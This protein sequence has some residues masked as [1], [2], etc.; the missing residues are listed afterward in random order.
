[1]LDVHV[2]YQSLDKFLDKCSILWHIFASF[3]LRLSVVTG[4]T[5]TLCIPFPTLKQLP[6]I[7][8]SIDSICLLPCNLTW[9][10]FNGRQLFEY[11]C[12][13]LITTVVDLS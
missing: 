7:F 10:I 8:G 13:I 5:V 12:K 2:Q 3:C 9:F 1:M 11:T 6:G 4:N